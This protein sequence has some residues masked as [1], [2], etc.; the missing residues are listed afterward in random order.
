MKTM[1]IKT[2]LRAFLV[3]LFGTQIIHAEKDNSAK[4]LK[5]AI[6]DFNRVLQESNAAIEVRKEIDGYRAQFQDEIQKIED[7]L[8]DLEKTLQTEAQKKLSQE[9]ESK[10]SDFEKRVSEVQEKTTERSS[11][12]GKAL[13]DAFNTIQEKIKEILIE[14]SERDHLTMVFPKSVVILHEPD[15]EITQEVLTKLNTVLPKVKV[16]IPGISK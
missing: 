5:I 14:I 7:Q 10:R 2:I 13:D 4:P 8:R 9:I 6:L 12:L 3:I 11:Q 1:T 15:V 16:V